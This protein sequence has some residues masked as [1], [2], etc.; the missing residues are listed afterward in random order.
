MSSL[1]D[2]RFPKK[3]NFFLGGGTTNPQVSLACPSVK[4]GSE[5]DKYEVVMDL[6][7]SMKNGKLGEKTFPLP[8]CRPQ[9]SFGLGRHRFF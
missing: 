3:N 2:S 6:L 4:S 1:D 9:I 8:L 7:L 5:D